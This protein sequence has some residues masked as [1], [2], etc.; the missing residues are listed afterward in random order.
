[1]I[2][3]IVRRLGVRAANEAR[4][5]VN[6][7][8]LSIAG[9]VAESRRRGVKRRPRSAATYGTAMLTK[10]NF[11]LIRSEDLEL[12]LRL[13]QSSET[14]LATSTEE[15]K[16]IVAACIVDP[17]L[18]AREIRD[19]LQ[20]ENVCVSTIRRRLHEAGIYSRI[21]AQKALLDDRH[22]KQRIKFASDV[23]S[24]CPQKWRS[25]VFTGD[26][27]FCTRW[28]HSRSGRTCVHMWGA[29]SPDGL[30]PLRRICGR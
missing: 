9:T 30:G 15:D 23:E 24:W 18:S 5:R 22:R 4:R 28:G 6:A 26:T 16:L 3:A 13:S 17:F 10:F 29:I 11:A 12:K 1:M 21:A 27:S 19:E 25:V 2:D 7:Q 20:L 14:S 8:R